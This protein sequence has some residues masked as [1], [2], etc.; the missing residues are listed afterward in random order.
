MRN[1]T[2][3]GL[4]VAAALACALAPS[5]DPPAPGSDFLGCETG[6][7]SAEAP[8]RSREARP[9]PARP[10]GATRDLASPDPSTGSHATAPLF[11]PELPPAPRRL[12]TRPILY[13]QPPPA[14]HLQTRSVNA[15]RRRDCSAALDAIAEGMAQS[16]D[17]AVLYRGAWLCFEKAHQERLARAEAATW[18]DFVHLLEHFEG[19]PEM[20]ASATRSH[21]DRRNRP[22]WYRAPVG[23]IEYRLERFTEDEQLVDVVD[24]LF[25]RPTVADHLA[26]D[27]HLEAL[28]AHGLSRLPP[29]ERTPALV[30]SWARRVYYTAWALRHRPGRR[31]AVARPELL[32]ELRRLLDEATRPPEGSDQ[33]VPEPVLEARRIAESTVFRPR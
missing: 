8:L 27:V 24:D 19:T 5:L 3:W 18:N 29:D 32:P 6:F 26:A 17:H 11:R 1:M 10:R 30:D 12:P 15:Y 4:G 9:D 20:M 33:A 13:T 25:G 14:G 31:I 2:T 28:A 22:R 7:E 21:P 23:G 16:I